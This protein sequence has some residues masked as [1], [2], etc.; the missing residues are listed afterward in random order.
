MRSSSRARSSDRTL[1]IASCAPTR[2][3]KDVR[4]DAE[5]LSKSEW[6]DNDRFSNVRVV[7]A[8]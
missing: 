1:S 6:K 7:L 4:E 2:H 8:T 5:E 3:W